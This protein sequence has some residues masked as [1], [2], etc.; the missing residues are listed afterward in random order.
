MSDHMK[1]FARAAACVAACI[2]ASAAR[3]EAADDT[4]ASLDTA[5]NIVK[6]G[7]LAGKFKY[8]SDTTYWS[9]VDTTYSAGT[10]FDAR[11]CYWKH[12]VY[13]DDICAFPIAIGRAV[14]WRVTPPQGH[15]YWDACPYWDLDIHP[16]YKLLCPNPMPGWPIQPPSPPMCWVGGV[17]EG[18]NSLKATWH[19]MKAHSC[20]GFNV[21]ATA[22]VVDGVRLHN[23]GDGVQ[24]YDSQD[25]IVRNCWFSHIRDEPLENDGKQ[26]GTMED[27]LVDGCYVFYS[28]TIG[29]TIPG[30]AT[31]KMV[32]RNNIVSLLP[33]PGPYSKTVPEGDPTKMGAGMLFKIREA[34]DTPGLYVYD[35]VFVL[36][37]GCRSYGDVINLLDS[38]RKESSGNTLI[39]LGD[40]D[41]TA[42][43][44]PGFTL[45]TGAKGQAMW[46]SLK[47]D[48]IERH[49]RVGRVE[50]D[51]GYGETESVPRPRS[52]N[53]SG[54]RRASVGEET[55]IFGMD[56]RVVGLIHE[57]TIDSAFRGGHLPVGVY[58]VSGGA[59]TRRVVVGCG[60]RR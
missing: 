11:G 56:G 51:P 24:L 55:M 15:A 45:V 3:T 4:F 36:Q 35:N 28:A 16:E 54:L 50:G 6:V 22:A 8:Y 7:K 37:K 1:T 12:Q 53:K 13:P 33:M 44:P 30:A 58:I 41:F 31:N 43:I 52:E 34:E 59:T 17:V 48:W 49:P 39:W 57:V 18:F 47:A 21:N 5:T 9:Y 23:T 20:S 42:T 14:D 27:C 19:D 46:D 29:K 60:I 32:I 10:V 25:F 38:K 40:G 26:S 2:T